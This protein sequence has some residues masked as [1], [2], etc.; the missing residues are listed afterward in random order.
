MTTSEIQGYGLQKLEELLSE[1]LPMCFYTCRMLLPDERTAMLIAADAYKKV[2]KNPDKLPEEDSFLPWIKNVVMVACATFLK[3][4]D[5]EFFLKDHPAPEI[6]KAV[7]HHNRNLNAAATA[8]Y[9]ENLIERLP[10]QVRFA[11][12]CYYYNGMT[13]AQIATVLSVPVLRVKELMRVAASAITD[14]TKEFNNKRVTTTKI[15]VSALLDLCAASGEYPQLDLSALAE[16]QAPIEEV[17]EPEAK[18]KKGGR[19]FLFVACALLVL[20]G[21]GVYLAHSFF[22]FNIPLKTESSS[23]ATSSEVG[24]FTEES[25]L[26]FI[27]NEPE[28]SEVASEPEQTEE[29]TFAPLY[30]VVRESFYDTSGEKTRECVYTYKGDKLVRQQT[31]TGMFTEDLKYTWNKKGNKR[32]SVDGNGNVCEKTWYDKQGNPIKIE[33]LDEP[34]NVVVY[35]WT[36]KRDEQGRIKSAAFKSVNSGKYLYEYTE[37]GQISK[38]TEVYGDDRY[39]TAY[40]YDDKGMVQTTVKTDFDGTIT[41]IFYTYDYDGLTFTA[42]Y[43]D[44]RKV[45]G[46]IA[47]TEQNN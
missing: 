12:L 29:N 30:R 25:E 32:T 43:S 6:E 46:T 8:K 3:K 34:T 47:A 31:A 2:L 37:Q 23:H 1:A 42:E 19:V 22:G 10:L 16:R 45:D 9:L 36:Y 4:Q 44:G 21:V 13:V 11:A 20:A 35:K 27:Y 38:L 26:D 28:E 33:F 14:L 15:D 18:P 40:T 7:V 39:T 17:L 24:S 5:E 41:E